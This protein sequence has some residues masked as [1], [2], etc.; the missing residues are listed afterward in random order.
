[1]KHGYVAI[2]LLVA[3]KGASAPPVATAPA[4][5]GDHAP[6]VVATPATDAGVGKGPPAVPVTAPVAFASYGEALAA[7]RTLAKDPAQ[8]AVAKAAFAAALTLQPEDAVALSELGW[9]EFQLGELDAALATT[10]R[11]IAAAQ[12]PRL[13][14]ASFYNR[15]RILEAQ[16]ERD[17]ASE[18]YRASL[19]LRPN[20]TVAARLDALVAPAPDDAGDADDADDAVDLAATHAGAVTL[21]TSYTDVHAVPWPKQGYR[22]GASC[23]AK[24][25]KVI[26]GDVEGDGRDEAVVVLTGG[27]E[28]GAKDGTD[29]TAH[30]YGVR[31][32]KVAWLGRIQG[33]GREH[34]EY[35]PEFIKVKLGKG[36]IRITWR[37]R[38]WGNFD[39]GNDEEVA[40]ET[41]QL[42]DGQVELADD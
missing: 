34:P 5:G 2:A 18:A 19:N 30:L 4:D 3:C 31:D 9:L 16:G 22:C 39:D 1:M 8:R 28:T 13:L 11:A 38:L 14:A 27:F 35:A 26:Y 40:V 33:S 24:L 23:T 42:V 25:T 36:R 17:G 32:G 7:G 29:Q 21:L 10:A 12:E 20:D 6:S 15:G 41:Y 37:F